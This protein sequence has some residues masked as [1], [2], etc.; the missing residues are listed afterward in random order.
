MNR[1][2]SIF[3]QLVQWFDSDFGNEAVAAIKAKPDK[4]EWSRILPFII[5]HL[6]CVAV[7]LVGWSWIAI[8]TA[9]G[10]YLLRMFAI[11]GFYHRYFSHKSFN[12]TRSAQ[13]IFAVIGGAAV[14][15][16][17]LW[18]AYQHRHHHQHSDEEAD[19]HSPKRRPTIRRCAI[20]QNSPSSF[21]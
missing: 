3:I 13:F 2:K 16:G 7:F 20:S 21:S 17:P 11:T 4:V 18:W 12:T 8:G 19:V 1:L 14:Q 9:I 6:G 10:L 5:L 15:R